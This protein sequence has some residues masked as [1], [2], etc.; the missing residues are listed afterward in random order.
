V[1]INT[2]VVPAMQI[3]GLGAVERLT[4]ALRP[5]PMTVLVMRR[6]ASTYSAVA[7]VAAEAL[8]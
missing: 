4:N 3:H 5:V 1:P 6:H 2:R 8:R 7:K